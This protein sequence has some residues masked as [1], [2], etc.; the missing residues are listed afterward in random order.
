[1]KGKIRIGRQRKNNIKEWTGMDFVSTTKAA[2][3]RTRWKGNIVKLSVLS[4]RPCNVDL[5]SLCT[6][7]GVNKAVGLER[8]V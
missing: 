1:M 5:T 3:D 7:Q 4:Q 6:P 2:E 8:C